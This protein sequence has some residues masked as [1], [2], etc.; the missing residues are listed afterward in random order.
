MLFHAYFT[1]STLLK[2]YQ[3]QASGT[4]WEVDELEAEVAKIYSHL[5]PVSVAEKMKLLQLIYASLFLRTSHLKQSSKTASTASENEFIANISITRSLLKMIQK[6]LASIS[7]ASDY[8]RDYV[9]LKQ[10]VENA[11]WKLEICEKITDSI[12]HKVTN[13]KEYLQYILTCFFFIRN[14]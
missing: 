14:I 11:L 6:T 8:Q 10:K 12:A 1:I 3:R 13:H 2:L 5:S 7:S 4:P 9:V